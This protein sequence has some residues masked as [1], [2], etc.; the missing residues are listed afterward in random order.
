IFT[1]D[2]TSGSV[3]LVRINDNCFESS[4]VWSPSGNEIAIQSRC[5]DRIVL[6]A[7]PSG[8]TS[9]VPC[10]DT[11][12]SECAGE[13]PTWSGDGNWLA[14]EDG[15]QILKVLKTGGTAQVVYDGS[16]PA[17]LKD[18]TEPSWSPDS[19]WIAFVQEDSS[20]V[21]SM[22]NS[23]SYLHIWVSDSRGSSFGLWQVTSGPFSD[24][25]PNWSSDSRFI[26]FS[27]NR[28][29]PSQHEIWKVGFS[30]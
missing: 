5:P 8:D 20:F 12:G 30:F 15:L 27:S 1:V 2:A 26:Y 28:S 9:T 22:F 23:D 19:K 6:V 21:D 17:V 4:P 7:Y 18:V 25:S 16:N 24:R 11:D 14:F 13:G 29:G 10:V 3:N